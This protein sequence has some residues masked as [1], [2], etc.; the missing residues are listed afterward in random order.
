MDIRPAI[1]ELKRSLNVM[2][3]NEPINR[4]EGNR[5]QADL[6]KENAKSFK[7]AIAILKESP[8]G[9]KT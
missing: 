3:T 7:G 9:K 6:E 4:R 2:R 5:P 8:F 1:D